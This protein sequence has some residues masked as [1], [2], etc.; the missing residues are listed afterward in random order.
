MIGK[1]SLT[2]HK[3]KS[4]NYRT[5]ALKVLCV[6]VNI[7]S[8]IKQNGHILKLH[9]GLTRWWFLVHLLRVVGRKI[10]YNKNT[11][12][13]ASNGLTADHREWFTDYKS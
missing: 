1:D 9:I 11:D 7:I 5:I 8:W 4:V 3:C 2:R 12:S 13:A 6:P 10:T